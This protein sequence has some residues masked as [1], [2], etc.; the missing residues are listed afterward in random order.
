MTSTYLCTGF[1]AYVREIDEPLT[2]KFW[3]YVTLYLKS[4]ANTQ[5]TWDLGSYV[6]GS[7][8]T[9]WTAATA[10]TTVLNAP[11]PSTGL[12]FPVVPVVPPPG[13]QTITA[14]A[15]AT[16]AIA[17]LAQVGVLAE[18]PLSVNGPGIIPYAQ[19]ASSASTSQ[20]VLSLTNNMIN[21]T[22]GTAS[23]PTSVLAY[24]FAW[25]LS[26]GNHGVKSPLVY[27]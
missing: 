18:S 10:D 5:L 9:F 17:L 3:Q 22:W 6:A 24:V 13:T 25:D 2:T 11:S 1:E 23:A 14:G 27:F 8:G 26:P 20:Y 12:T 16:Q 21:I 19:V 15:V 4:T 7:L